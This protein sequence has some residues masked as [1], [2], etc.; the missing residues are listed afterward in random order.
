MSK[1]TV[2]YFEKYNICK[3]EMTVSQSMASLAWI[4]KNGFLPLEK[5]SK[6]IDKSALDGNGLYREKK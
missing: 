1:V 5:T 3:D 6:T 4:K 2:Y